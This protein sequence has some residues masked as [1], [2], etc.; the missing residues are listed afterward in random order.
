MGMKDSDAVKP[1][2]VQGKNVVLI[3]MPGSGKSTIGARL[4]GMLGYAYI[5]TDAL[6]EKVTGRSLQ[7]IVDDNGYLTLREIEEKV[8]LSF[9]PIRYVVSTGGSAVYSRAAMAHLKTNGVIVFLNV[10]LETLRK[11]IKNFGERGIA[12]HPEQSFEDLYRERFPLYVRYADIIIE[13]TRLS[14]DEI[15]E[16]I[17]EGLRS[18]KNRVAG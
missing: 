15:C 7:K 18:E 5:D 14:V 17:I 8:L 10:D 11:R 16:R 1:D 3:G 4:A 13:G 12:K 2:G 6:I 9:D